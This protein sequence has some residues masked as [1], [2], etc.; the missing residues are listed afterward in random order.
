MHFYKT[1]VVLFFAALFAN[2]MAS[3]VGNTIEAR[4]GLLNLLNTNCGNTEMYCCDTSGSKNT[5]C[6]KS[7]TTCSSSQT[8]C[9]TGGI[10][11][12]YHSRPLKQNVFTTRAISRYLVCLKCFLEANGYYQ[13][14]D[15]GFMGP[16]SLV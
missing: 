9:C 1:N 3:P 12:S 11:G 2:G 16:T 4:D 13:L 5:N 10:L 14:R 8:T 7:T 6:Q 15:N